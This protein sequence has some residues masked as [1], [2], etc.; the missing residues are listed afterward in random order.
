MESTI[1]YVMGL[2]LLAVAYVACFTTVIPVGGTKRKIGFAAVCCSVSLIIVLAGP[3][4]FN[5]N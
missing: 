1:F 2:T 4:L 3:A 5:M